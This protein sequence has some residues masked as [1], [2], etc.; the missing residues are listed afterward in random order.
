M[1]FGLSVLSLL[2]VICFAGCGPSVQLPKWPDPVPATG[3]IVFDDKPLSGATVTFSPLEQTQGHG[4]IGTTDDAGK[5]ELRSLG[6][7]GKSRVGAIPGKYRV[8]VS[9]MVKPDGSVWKP[10]PKAPGGPM[11]SG[12][13]EEMPRQ[14]A[15]ESKLTAEV[16]SGKSPYDFKL[17]K[18]KK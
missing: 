13:R 6:P 16:A 18:K 12:A 8:A 5:Y 14:Y 1:R 4:A 17:E 2:G 7:D 15:L 9:R 3:P 10:D 11:N